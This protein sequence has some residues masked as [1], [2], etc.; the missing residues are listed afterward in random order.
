MGNEAYIHYEIDDEEWTEFF[1]IAEQ[2]IIMADHGDFVSGWQ[3]VCGSDV[4]ENLPP[5]ILEILD[6][7]IC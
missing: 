7:G 1:L 4:F 6:G 5:H 2:D 3:I